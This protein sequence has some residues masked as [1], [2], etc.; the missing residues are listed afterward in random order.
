MTGVVLR[1]T[2][3]RTDFTY[4]LP[5]DLIAQH[6]TEKR[7]ASRLLALDGATGGLADLAFRD[8]PALLRP[9][10]LL[11]FNDTRVVPARIHG[12]KDSG[13][14]IEILLERA[15]GPTSALVHARAS[16]GLKTGARVSLPGGVSARMQ[17]REG[18]LFRLDFTVAVVPYFEGHGDRPL[19]PYVSRAPE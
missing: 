7:S 6:P 14:R 11:V 8:L 19:P 18:E 9:Q 5:P 12:T 2:M 17:G 10:D 15:I 13:G 3:Q 4:D 16:K 1:R